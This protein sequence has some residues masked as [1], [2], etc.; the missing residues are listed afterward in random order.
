LAGG[1]K[2]RFGRGLN[3]AV[4]LACEL[5]VIAAVAWWGFG[6]SWA[7]GVAAPAVVIAV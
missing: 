7:L 5:A 2:T 3:L 6:L 1:G 4:R